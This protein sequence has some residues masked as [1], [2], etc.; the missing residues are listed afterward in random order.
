DIDRFSLVQREAARPVFGMND[1]KA[2]LAEV[3]AHHA[4]K[5]GII[6]DQKDT[7]VHGGPGSIGG[8]PSTAMPVR[9]RTTGRDP[10]RDLPA[11]LGAEHFG[12]IGQRLRDAFARSFR[13]PDLL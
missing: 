11:L 12:G 2:R 3:L 13:K 10:I 6:F 4:G 8:Y 7:F 1:V 5:T 9:P